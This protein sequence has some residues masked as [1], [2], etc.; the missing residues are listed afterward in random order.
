M[1]GKF[2]LLGDK[3]KLGYLFRYILEFFLAASHFSS[4]FDLSTSPPPP[5][6]E[7]RIKCS[8]IDFLKLELFAYGH[9][10]N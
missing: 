9:T 6:K 8:S 10:H 2:S 5:P 3:G 1:R 7:S 4:H